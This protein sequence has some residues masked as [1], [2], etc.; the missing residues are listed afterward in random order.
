V[1]LASY[2]FGI[3]AALI[4]LFIVIELLRR[5]RLRERHAVYWLIAGVLAL[6]VGI[7]PQVLV[8]AA[9][10]VGIAVPTNLVFFV[11]IIILFFV[12]IQ[13]SSELT[14]LE[15]KTRLLAEEL[16]L[17]ELR[18]RQLEGAPAAREDEPDHVHGEAG[19]GSEG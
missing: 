11:S 1:S 3:L 12:C 4:T 15:T 10:L 9:S 8:W 7:F 17:Q 5:R 14:A 6:I 13:H 19:R 2:L 18:L 16:A